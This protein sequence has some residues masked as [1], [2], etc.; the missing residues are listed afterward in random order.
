[1]RCSPLL[2][3]LILLGGC[4]SSGS[5]GDDLRSERER[6]PVAAT[7]MAIFPGFFVHGAG[8]W[9]AG[10][11]NRRDELLEEEGLGLGCMALGAGLAGLGYYEHLQADREKGTE[12]VLNR[13]GEVSSFVGAAGFEGYGLVLFFDSWIRDIAEA[14][15]AAESRNREL[16]RNREYDQPIRPDP[17]V[18]DSNSADA[19][20]PGRPD[21]PPR[22]PG[23]PR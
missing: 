18:V 9:Y 17:A 3:S 21:V 10:R 20:V 15:D 6:S 1:M 11:N 7:L 23:A 8:N 19:I 22:K 5:S 12:Q 16:R 13:I 14:G 2:L 4:A